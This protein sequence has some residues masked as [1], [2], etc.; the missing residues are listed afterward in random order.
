MSYFED[1][2]KMVIKE[3]KNELKN[4]NCFIENYGEELEK[5]AKLKEQKLNLLN[6]ELIKKEKMIDKACEMLEIG[7]YSKEKYLSRV[8]VLE[9]E[10]N[11][12]KANMDELEASVQSDTTKIKKAIPIL[13]KVLDIYWTLNARDKNDILKSI[14]DRIEYTKTKY[15]TRWN[16]KLDDLQLK[17]FLK[18]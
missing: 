5:E 1:V 3:L 16:K 2:E 15:N 17:I 10:K 4:F 12:I 9:E 11:K 13:E 14:I 6:K 7:V 8:S 18:I